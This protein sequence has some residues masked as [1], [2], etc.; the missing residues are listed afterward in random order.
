[1]NLYMKKE[2][3]F[4]KSAAIAEEIMLKGPPIVKPQQNIKIQYAPTFPKV[5]Y[6]TKMKKIAANKRKGGI[7][8]ALIFFF[9][10]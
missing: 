5:A 2:K 3:I 4:T 6:F 1:M 10:F 7:N 9:N 8:K